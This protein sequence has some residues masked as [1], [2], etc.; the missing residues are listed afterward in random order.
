MEGI[1]IQTE[2]SEQK[3]ITVDLIDRLSYSIER[4]LSSNH[5]NSLALQRLA[6]FPMQETKPDPENMG[7]E[8]GNLKMIST[9]ITVL[10]T[11]IT[12]AEE[13]TYKLTRIA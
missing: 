1:S 3:L 9:L 13:N 7:E 5:R 11:A 12:D 10:D 2:I 6:G 4:L 8:H